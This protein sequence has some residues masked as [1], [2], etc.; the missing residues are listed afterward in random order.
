MTSSGSR[1][2]SSNKGPIRY[3][4]EDQNLYRGAGWFESAIIPIAK[5][6]P[7]LGS[8]VR[9]EEMIQGQS[10]SP[11]HLNNGT[12]ELDNWDYA[13]RILAV[14]LDVLGIGAGA[15]RA[16]RSPSA[17]ASSLAPAS[18]A[19]AR[20]AADVARDLIAR[21][22][23][24]TRAAAAELNGQGLPQS[25]VADILTEMFRQSGRDIAGTQVLSDGTIILLSRRVGSNQPIVA[26]DKAGQA[27][28]GSAKLSADLTKPN[29]PIVATEIELP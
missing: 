3:L 24:S 20:L 15:C 29:A 14:G 8:V 18:G 21:H 25:R 26:I 4:A 19:G 5:N 28:F 6:V 27:K 10:I 1:K 17:P 12:A 23:G 13:G 2:S 7:I 11:Y 9:I 16:I 22:G